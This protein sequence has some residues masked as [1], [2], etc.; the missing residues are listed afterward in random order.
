MNMKI[1]KILPYI[2]AAVILAAFSGCRD[3]NS[4]TYRV[5]TEPLELNIPPFAS[6]LYILNPDG[7]MDFSVAKQPDYGFVASVNYGLEVSL[8]KEKIREIAPEKLTSSNIEVK[9]SEFA[10]AMCVL[11]GIESSDDWDAD[12]AARAPQT[13]YVRATA[14]LPGVDGSLVTSEWVTLDKVQPYFAVPEPGFIYL[15]GTPEGWVG[16]LP[17]NAAHYA[18]WRLFES[19]TAIGSKV[20]SGVFD[21]PAAPVFRFYTALGSWDENS[22]GSQVEDNPVE[23]TL[24]DGQ[25]QGKLVAGKG[26]LSFPDF[27]GGDMTIVVDLND[28]SIQIMA[29]AQAVVDPKYIYLVGQPVGWV[30]PCEANKDKLLALVDKTDSGIYTAEYT[31]DASI[32]WFNFRFTKTLAPEEEGAWDA[33]EWIGCPDG[34]NYEVD[35][36]FSGS[37]DSSQNTWRIMNAVAGQTIKFTV[38]TSTEPATVSFEQAN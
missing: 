22:L 33:V 14:E 16:P 30:A 7:M 11:N 8:D 38:N 17:E 18:D 34:D 3:D 35:M 31:L 13:V 21:M 25:W 36:P 9:E 10:T 37:A 2:A 4:P 15:V 12:P 27:P 28:N 32:D 19:K 20:Y 5:P 1:T 6:Q 23:Y 29:G 24:T 26:S